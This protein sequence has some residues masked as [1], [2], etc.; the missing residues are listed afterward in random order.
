[1]PADLAVWIPC[2]EQRLYSDG[3]RS[4]AGTGRG[5]E[6]EEAVTEVTNVDTAEH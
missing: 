5:V 3:T 1:M 4:Q 2:Q 6:E